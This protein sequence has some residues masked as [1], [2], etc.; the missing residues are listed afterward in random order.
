MNSALEST[1]FD[2]FRNPSTR[3]ARLGYTAFEL[4]RQS[5]ISAA[6]D[7]PRCYINVRRFNAGSTMADF[8][9]ICVFNCTDHYQPGFCVHESEAIEQLCSRWTLKKPQAASNSS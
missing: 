3:A 7:R 1:D 8:T 5:I 9:E 6:F 4:I 2:A